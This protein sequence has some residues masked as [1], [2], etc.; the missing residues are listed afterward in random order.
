[1]PVAVTYP[2]VYIEEIPSGVRTITGVATS[3]TAFVGRAPRGP[4]NEPTIISSY[5]DFERAFGGLNAS[6][7]V[8]YAVRDFYMNGGSQGIIVRLQNG[9]TA[10]AIPLP[11]GSAAPNDTLPLV[12]ASVGSWGT[13]LTATVD[14]RTKDVADTTLFNL[15]IIE[16][17]GTT[18]TFLN[19]SI[20]PASSRFVP[21]VLENGSA[22][23]RVKRDGDQ[24]VVPNARPKEAATPADKTGKDGANLRDQDSRGSQSDKTGLFALEKADLFN[25]LCIP[26]DSRTGDTAAAVYQAAMAYCAARRAMLIVDPP[27]GWSSAAKITDNTNKALTDLGLSGE[28]ARN[29]ALYFPR[30]LAADPPR[31]TSRRLSA[32]RRR[33]RVMACT[34]S[35]RGVWRPRPDSTAPMACRGS[36]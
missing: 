12:A 9:G 22:L 13:N 5:G 20:D 25:L 3:I 6:Y 31:R 19:V 21:R 18:E 2:G 23:V 15:T 17:G 27:V 26:P 32:V 10:A 11:T 33:R 28:A 7:P 34:D 30:I 4:V 29:A 35:T 14:Y 8:S 24:W 1:M 36:P 16:M